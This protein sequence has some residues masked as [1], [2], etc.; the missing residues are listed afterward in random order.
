M[1]SLPPTSIPQPNGTFLSLRGLSRGLTLLLI[2]GLG[3][4]NGLLIKQNRDLKSTIAGNQPDFL[5]PGQ[6]VRSFAAKTLSGQRQ[7]VNYSAR[8]KTVLLV[9]TPQCPACE[10]SLPYWKA[11]KEACDRNQYQIFGISLDSSSE[12]AGFLTS[13]GLNLEVFAGI[14]AEF[15]NAYKLNLTPLTIAID[16]N[17]KVEKIWPGAFNEKS[18]AEVE[19]YFGISPDDVK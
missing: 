12:T 3:I 4:A 8:A 17:G 9:F 16:N 5:K 7:M 18:K 10:R 15:R 1:Q 6:Q 2:L 14:D 11:I 19:S 13:N